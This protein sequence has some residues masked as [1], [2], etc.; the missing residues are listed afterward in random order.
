MLE[1]AAAAG[2]SRVPFGP[3]IAGSF[4]GTLP[5]IFA[6]VEAGQLSSEIVLSGTPPSW[7]VKLGLGATLGAIV[8][9]GNLASTTLKN[10]DVDLGE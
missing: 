6:Y 1:R 10:L 9:I 4:L 7:L 2:I 5:A 8:V 3:Y